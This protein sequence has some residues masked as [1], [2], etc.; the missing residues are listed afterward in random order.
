MAVIAQACPGWVRQTD[1]DS[2][3][4]A[5]LEAWGRADPQG[6]QVQ[7]AS[8][9]ARWSD[10]ANGGI[11]G[12]QMERLANSLHLQ[13]AYLPVVGQFRRSPIPAIRAHLPTSY[14][15]CMYTLPGFCHTVLIYRLRD[16]DVSFMDPNGGVYLNRPHSWLNALAPF[17][18]LWR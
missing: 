13:H 2:C 1:V 11:S 4:A 6:P 8:L 16:H 7:Q 15:S 3:W 17:G 9:I 14:V 18:L 12:T 10:Q 5:A